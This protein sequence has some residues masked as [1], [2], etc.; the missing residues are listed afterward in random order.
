MGAVYYRVCTSSFVF[1]KRRN[2]RS[3]NA[4][5]VVSRFFMP[6]KR[7]RRKK[8]Q[9]YP[10]HRQWE[11]AYRDLLNQHQLRSTSGANST[12]VDRKVKEIGLGTWLVSGGECDHKVTLASKTGP[13]ICLD[14]SP[15]HPPAK[16]GY[17]CG[18][19]LA[20]YKM[21][22]WKHIPNLFTPDGFRRRNRK[23]MAN[24]TIQRP[25]SGRSISSDGA[26]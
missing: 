20:V 23:V 10:N 1:P 21:L 25:P 18:H 5:A 6:T 7:V 4:N 14:H 17:G 22:A 12:S 2:T 24:G 13:L 3:P 8:T 9:P 11:I 15:P 19:V 16:P 26:G